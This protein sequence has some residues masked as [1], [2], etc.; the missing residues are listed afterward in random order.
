MQ[1]TGTHDP[2]SVD[3]LKYARTAGRKKTSGQAPPGS[4][5]AK[6]ANAGKLTGGKV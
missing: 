6:V 2:R 5:G 4:M 3:G 1:E